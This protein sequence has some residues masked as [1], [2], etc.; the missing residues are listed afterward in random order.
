MNTHLFETLTVLV[1]DMMLPANGLAMPNV[2][3]FIYD[4]LVN[5]GKAIHTLYK[6]NRSNKMGLRELADFVDMVRSNAA[7]MREWYN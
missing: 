3:N 4:C 2:E 5:R 6:N 1:A 7:V